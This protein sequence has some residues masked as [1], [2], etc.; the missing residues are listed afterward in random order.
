MTTIVVPAGWAHRGRTKF[1][2]T[3]GRLTDVIKA[4]VIA[5]P[6]Y[7]RRLLGPDGEPFSYFNVY[8]DDEFV[9]RADRWETVVRPGA[10]V[11]ILP[12]LNGG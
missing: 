3:A 2:G 4:F 5:N 10:T 7:K 6:G 1:E 11:T 12:P 8:L 9:P